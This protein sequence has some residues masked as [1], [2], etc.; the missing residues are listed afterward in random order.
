MSNPGL[1]ITRIRY[2][3]CNLSQHPTFAIPYAYLS[4]RLLAPLADAKIQN[5]SQIPTPDSKFSAKQQ[6]PPRRIAH[7]SSDI[8]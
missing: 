8:S 6:G 3:G 2:Y 5:N 7:K 4:A 1:G